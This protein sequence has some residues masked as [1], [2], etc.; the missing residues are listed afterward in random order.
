[1][2]YANK[3]EIHIKNNI[4]LQPCTH[5]HKMLHKTKE[6]LHEKI[7]MLPHA[8]WYKNVHIY[9]F[10]LEIMNAYGLLVSTWEEEDVLYPSPLPFLLLPPPPP[11]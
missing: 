4:S 11:P 5:S 2:Y 7:W 3:I 9:E 10:F 8:P 6:M 1:M